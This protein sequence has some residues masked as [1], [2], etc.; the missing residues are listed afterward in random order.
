MQHLLKWL[1]TFFW[2]ILAVPSLATSFEQKNFDQL[3]AEAEDIFAGTAITALP[4]RLAAGGIVTDVTFSNL[5]IVKGN[6]ASTEISLM[7]MGGTIGTETMQ[8]RG[9]PKFQTGNTYLIFSQGNGTTIFPVVGGDQG[10]FQIR[11]D[12]VTGEKRVYSANGMPIVNPSV[13]QALSL[14]APASVPLAVFLEAIRS[15]MH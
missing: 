10:M 5:Q 7:T 3:V 8:I 4:R 13:L 6:S 1:L 12:V 9:L 15:R 14:Q 11:S 2:V